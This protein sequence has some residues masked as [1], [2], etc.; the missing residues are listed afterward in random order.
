MIIDD[1]TKT[2]QLVFYWHM[3]YN[4]K[5]AQHT[6]WFAWFLLEAGHDVSLELTQR[7]RLQ[8]LKVYLDL[9]RVR[10]LEGRLTGLDNVDHATQFVS[11]T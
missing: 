5:C 8:R 1:V 7:R 2:F 6:W 4:I 3:V 10:V 9:V 11:Y